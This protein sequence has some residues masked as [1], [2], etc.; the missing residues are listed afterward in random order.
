MGHLIADALVML[1]MGVA[2]YFGHMPYVL[3][4]VILLIAWGVKLYYDG[5]ALL[6]V[7]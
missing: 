5:K 4:V 1:W 3:V 2:W 6:E 7:R